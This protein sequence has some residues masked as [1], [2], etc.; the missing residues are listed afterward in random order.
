MSGD[1]QIS[2]DDAM[3][4][5]VSMRGELLSMV[6]AKAEAREVPET[7]AAFQMW[8]LKQEERLAVLE[9]CIEIVGKLEV[10]AVVAVAEGTGL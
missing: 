1:L 3:R 4:I 5:L 9:A 2:R 6:R 8:I 7:W 10:G